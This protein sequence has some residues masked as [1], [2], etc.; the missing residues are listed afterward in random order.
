MVNEIT[1]NIDR[2]DKD[3]LGGV[4]TIYLFKWV[5]YTRAQ[6]IL[7]GQKLIQFPGTDIYKVYSSTTN[8]NQNTEVEGGAVSF[9]QNLTIEITKSELSSQLYTTPFQKYRAIFVD[10]NGNYRMAGLWNGLTA[11]W[12]NETGTNEADFNGYRVTF[13]GL[14]DMQA[15]WM[16]GFAPS[17]TPVNDKNYIFQNGDDYIFQDG[18]NFIFN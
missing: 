3:L 13:E 6:I 18:S 14:E 4:Q 15:V 16:T 12:S 11:T 10:K 2:P 7:E 5:K 9:K 8:F 1:R 17:I